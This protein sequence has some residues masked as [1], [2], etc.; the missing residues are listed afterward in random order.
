V[1]LQC[2]QRW[3]GALEPSLLEASSD[4]VAPLPLDA[5]LDV[6]LEL[7]SRGCRA[8]VNG[9]V[10]MGRV[11][12]APARGRLWVPRASPRKLCVRI[13]FGAP[14]GA[15]HR[16]DGAVQIGAPSPMWSLS[17]LRG[18]LR[19]GARPLGR[20]ELRFDLRRDLPAL[21]R[22]VRVVPQLPRKQLI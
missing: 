11:V 3:S 12:C 10:R 2:T 20:V 22:S 9:T 7:S 4:P 13:S 5:T 6:R 16:L 18:T 8:R 15:R 14:G 21:L 1:A 17:C 19:A